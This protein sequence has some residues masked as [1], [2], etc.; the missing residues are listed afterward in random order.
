MTRIDS[1]GLTPVVLALLAGPVHAQPAP[2]PL[3]ILDV[4]FVSQS[5]ALCGGAAAAM[6][7]RYW[8]ERGLDAESF[9]HLVDRSAGGIRTDRLVGDL[10][11]RGWS[12]SGL[13]GTGERISA[14]LDRGRPVLALI[15]DR[16]GTFHYVVVVAATPK[17]VVFHDPARAPFRVMTIE[18]FAR[19]WAAADR[20]MAIVVPG[21][22]VVETPPPS[23]AEPPL[24]NSCAALIDEG[25][26]LA[27]SN[28]LDAAERSLTAALSCGGSAPLREMAGLRLLQRRWSDVGETAAAALAIDPGDEHAWDLLATSRFVQDD[29]VGALEA[30]NRID[31][32][33]VDLVSV[34]GLEQ[35]GQRAVERLMGVPGEALLT[36]RLFTVTRRRLQELP[37]AV[38]TRLEYR[39]AASG[40]A[41]VRAHVVE[42]PLLPFSKSNYLAM[43]LLAVARS[44]IRVS[45]GSIMGGGERVSGSWRFWPDR[46]RVDAEIVAPAPW[47]GLWGVEGFGERQ[48]FTDDGI[49]TARRAGA[50]V[51]LSNWINPWL[52]LWARGGVDA[53]EEHG[54]FGLVAGGLRSASPR[55]RVVIDVEGSGWSGGDGFAS[56]ATAATVRSSREHR[57]RVYIARAGAAAA[58]ASTPPDIWFGGDTGRARPTLLRAHPIIEDGALRVEQIGRRIVHISVEARQWWSTP[59]P[60]R[61]GAA[62]FVDSAHVGNR[63]EAD[64]QGDVDTGLGARLAVPGLDGVFRL[65]VAKGLRDGGTA[66]SFV[67]EP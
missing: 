45:T 54:R 55:E 62:L 9:A 44:E 39:P 28:A 49:P 4:P 26:R 67:Y 2:E 19:R 18:T 60:I 25:I 22:A 61:V 58:T 21:K 66:F 47:G 11:A 41:E 1:W 16:P 38:G 57:G 13:E 48:P 32:P 59:W 65:D 29:P 33:R 14:E 6:I 46:P 10:R 15:E 35:T 17:A 40:L 52:R 31:R 42:R 3:T 12:A 63:F 34:D 51:T 43:G 53:W 27:Q 8:G 5:E 24:A 50:N 64:A 30:W 20:W 36:S 7:L 56:L 23:V 37:S